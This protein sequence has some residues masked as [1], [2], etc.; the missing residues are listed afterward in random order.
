MDDQLMKT[1]EGM[2]ILL[3]SI[4]LDEIDVKE[5]LSGDVQAI[6]LYTMST[7]F[8]DTMEIETTC[9]NCKKTNSSTI[10]FSEF[11][12]MDIPK[13][14][15]ENMVIETILPVSK[16][17]VSIKIPNF[18]DEMKFANSKFVEKLKRII[19]S[20]D[21][22]SECEEEKKQIGSWSIKDSQHIKKFIKNNTPGVDMTKN[23]TCV[24]CL[25]QYKK[26]FASDHNFLSLP[27]AYQDSLDSEMTLLSFHNSGIG[28]EDIN[29][30]SIARRRSILKKT[31]EE[32]KRFNGQKDES[33]G[34]ETKMRYASGKTETK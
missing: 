34:I 16:I 28:W 29:N 33:K 25:K 30:M 26:E 23:F 32:A 11:K 17:K 3:K 10:R 8:G 6:S 13:K 5:L 18:F 14:P 15:D 12:I 4:I 31:I 9:D 7:S 20:I 27:A 21:G 24:H 22:N 19:V 1:P 2:E